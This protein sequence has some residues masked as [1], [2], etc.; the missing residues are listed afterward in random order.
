M[1]SG[2]VYCIV[3][4]KLALVP[5]EHL[6]KI[7]KKEMLANRAIELKNLVQSTN[8]SM[9]ASVAGLELKQIMAKIIRINRQIPPVVQFVGE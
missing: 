7:T 9:V 2:K 3:D 5:E 6:E 1:N 4:G 8:D